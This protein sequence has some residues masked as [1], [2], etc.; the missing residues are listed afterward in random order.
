MAK[1]RRADSCKQSGPQCVT[2]LY[3]DFT[4][5]LHKTEYGKTGYQFKSNWSDRE[6]NARQAAHQAETPYHL[7][8]ILAETVARFLNSEEIFIKLKKKV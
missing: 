6:E 8:Q 1:N 4:R 2:Y 3:S 7:H 5:T